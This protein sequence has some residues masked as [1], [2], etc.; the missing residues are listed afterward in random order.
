M[1]IKKLLLTKNDCYKSNNKIKPIGIVVHSTGA[2]NPYLKRYIGPDDGI[3]GV[4]KNNNTWNRSGIKKCVHAMIGKDKM[5]KVQVYQ[6]LPF[7]IAAWG[8]G[9][10]IK[11]SYNYNPTAH[12]QFEIC[13]DD[14]TDETYFNEAFNNAIE[15]CVYLCQEYNLKPSTIISHN[16][17][18][19]KGYASNHRDC[20]HWLKKFNKDMDWFRNEVDK[21]LNN[22]PILEET[23]YLVKI[24]TQKLNVRKGPSVK[25]KIIKTIKQNEVYTII[26]EKNGWG[27]LKNKIGWI[28]LNYTKKITK[29]SS[30]TKT[31]Y[32]CEYLNIRNKPNIK[33]TILGKLKKGT[34]V[35][36]YKTQNNWSKIDSTNEKWVSSKYLK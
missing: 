35:T 23:S 18:Y 11:G 19:Q 3:I 17:A 22:L 10:G 2:N 34:K 13:E 9:K 20:N 32:N 27:L 12:I 15:L 28:S 24:N 7:N 5:G 36:I 21:K 26:E 25:E 14:L 16:E 30:N 31:I 1:I 33:G 8:V 6:T 4:N 29:T